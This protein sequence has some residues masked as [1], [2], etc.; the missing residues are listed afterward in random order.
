MKLISLFLFLSFSVLAS[1]SGGTR[2][3]G[4]V[5]V[6]KE[7]GERRVY[8]ADTFELIRGGSLIPDETISKEVYAEA[9]LRTIFEVHPELKV[10]LREIESKMVTMTSFP[11]GGLL[12]HMFPKLLG[13]HLKEVDNDHLIVEG[14]C[15]KG[16]LAHQNIRKARVTLDHGRWKALSRMEQ[17]IFSVHE[18]FINLRNATRDTTAVRNE[19]KEYVLNPRFLEQVVLV[20]N[21]VELVP[22]RNKVVFLAK[23][24]IGVDRGMTYT[25]RSEMAINSQMLGGNYARV[26]SAYGVEVSRVRLARLLNE[27]LFR[28]G[29]DQMDVSTAKA[30]AEKLVDDAQF[31][32]IVKKL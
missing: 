16:Q 4:D 19:I 31:P 26:C 14:E 30:I 22:R 28:P 2:G 15:K 27:Q 1:E 21:D 24:L 7:K 29:I 5:S 17:G 12:A 18:V 9:L 25:V 8:L 6:C 3:G 11:N 32:A 13:G 10:K 20:Q 23:V